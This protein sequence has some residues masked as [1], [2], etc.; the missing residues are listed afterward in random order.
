MRLSKPSIS[1]SLLLLCAITSIATPVTPSEK[2]INEADGL[3]DSSNVLPNPSPTST[4]KASLGRKDAPVDGKDGRP[5]AGP[6][7]ETEAQRDRKKAKESG[8]DEDDKPGSKPKPKDNLSG[9][10]TVEYPESNDGVM[11]DPNRI[12]PKEGTR[13]TEGGISEKSREKQENMDT[14]LSENKP[15]EPKEAPPLPHSEQEKLAAVEEAVPKNT[16]LEKPKAKPEELEL[17]GLT[18]CD[19]RFIK[20]GYSNRSRNLTI[21]LTSHTIFHT[22]CRRI[23]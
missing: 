19:S 22:P 18:V 11:D 6:W 2:A 13:G 9:K 8:Q 21:Y 4:T 12:G 17:G 3:L 14:Q 7:V 15:E 5:H 16:D 1:L 10:A 23:Y 20:P